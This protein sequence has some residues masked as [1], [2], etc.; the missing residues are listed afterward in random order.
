MSQKQERFEQ[1]DVFAAVSLQ[2]PE[3]IAMEIERTIGRPGRELLEIIMTTWSEAMV[4][5]FQR[6]W[7]KPGPIKVGIGKE[8]CGI[9]STAL[10]PSLAPNQEWAGEKTTSHVRQRIPSL[11]RQA[12]LLGAARFI[13]PARFC[14]ARMI[15]GRKAHFRNLELADV[16]STVKTSGG[17]LRLPISEVTCLSQRHSGNVGPEAAAQQCE[18]AD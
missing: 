12:E 17:K 3:A 4:A 16:V 14:R 5:I 1:T 8:I 10:F 7:R 9:Q 2:K 11:R 15:S 18:A 13:A 6:A